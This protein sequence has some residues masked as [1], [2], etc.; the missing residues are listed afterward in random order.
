MA[1][2]KE[3]SISLSGSFPFF[4]ERFQQHRSIEKDVPVLSTCLH[5]TC[6]HLTCPHLASSALTCSHLPSPPSAVLTYSYLSPSALT[7]PHLASP[8]LTCS[9]LP[10]P[11]PIC[12]T[13]S[14]LP[15]PPS[16][17]LTCLQLPHL[18]LPAFVCPH[19]SPSALTCSHLPSLTSGLTRPHLLLLALTCSHLTSTALPCPQHLPLF[20]QR[21]MWPSIGS[22]P[23]VLHV[24]FCVVWNLSR[25]VTYLWWCEQLVPT[26]LCLRL[27]PCQ[28]PHF[29]HPLMGWGILYGGCALV[30]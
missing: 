16:S 20:S 28:Q 10:L 25:I 3:I 29:I 8:A 7:W 19:L 6:P 30:Y 12:L 13:C 21:W 24:H 17:G 5:L 22:V 27:L 26:A 4:R 23:Q 14:H 18:A 15:S 2:G 9:H 1:Q 11:V